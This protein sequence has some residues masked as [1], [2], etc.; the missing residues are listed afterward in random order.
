METIHC[1]APFIS[2]KSRILI[3]GSM[4]SVRSLAEGFYYMHP[5]NR[6]YLVLS[7][8]TGE[9]LPETLAEKQDFLTRH[10]IALFDVIA[11]CRREGS[12]DAKIK[13]AIPNDIDALLS[14]YPNIR[15]VVTNGSLAAKLYLKHNHNALPHFALPSTSPIPRKDIRNADDLIK[16]WQAIA[17]LL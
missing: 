9:K 17:D 1:F 11:A 12:T 3:L 5:R 16:K 6:F 13:D 8:L 4:P 2:E 14:E 7:A 15:A 10:G